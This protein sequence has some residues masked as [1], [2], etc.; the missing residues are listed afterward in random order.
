[1][2]GDL[3]SRSLAIGNI[4]FLFNSIYNDSAKFETEETALAR[5]ILVDVQR[6]IENQPSAFNVEKAIQQL[7][8]LK[9]CK[10]GLADTMSEII[11]RGELGTYVCLEDVLEIVKSGG[12]AV[13]QKGERE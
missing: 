8:K 1:M 6:A 12:I 2:S 7:E 13:G 11:R 3:I 10:L 4:W 5:R 9:T